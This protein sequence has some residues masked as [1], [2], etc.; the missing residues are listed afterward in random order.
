MNV[1]VCYFCSNPNIVLGYTQ[2]VTPPPAGTIGVTGTVQ[3]NR[4][5]GFYNKAGSITTTG[6]SNL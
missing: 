2:I 3:T 5:I 1:G 4:T 6:F